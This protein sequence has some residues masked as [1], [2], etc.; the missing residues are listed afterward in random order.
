MGI[1]NK[2]YDK[3][4]KEDFM[5]NYK[6]DLSK[7][8]KTEEE[9][10]TAI[11]FID[12]EMK[13][14]EEL[15]ENPK[16]NLLSILDLRSS[17]S[18]TMDKLY[19][20]SHMK[21]DE[22]AN[23]S[24]NQK[25]AMEM[26]SLMNSIG[27]QFSFIEPLILGIEDKELN[28]IIDS[29]EYSIYKT[30]IKRVIRKK[31]HTLSEKEEFIL[32]TAS[33]MGDCAQNTFY[34]LSYGDMKFP[35]LEKT[36]EKIE[37]THA[38]YTNMLT[39]PN[40]N[41]RQEAF[42]KMYSTYDKYKN[43]F[44]S[45][46]MGAIKNLVIQSK[47]KNF[48]SARTLPLFEDD[49]DLSVYDSLISAVHDKLTTM[50]EY[51]EVKKKGLKLE[52][53]HMY[54]VYVPL[55]EGVDRKIPYEEAKSLI[56]EA[57]KPLGEDYV[58]I[59]KKAFD[60]SWID[61]YPREGK[62]SGAYS[63][64]CYDSNPYILMNYTDDLNSLFTLAHELGHSVH[65]YLS[66]KNNPYI[67]SRYTIFVAEVASTLNELLLMDYMLKTSKDEKEK[68]YLLN[69]HLEQFRTTVF[70]QTMFAEFEREIHKRVENKEALTAKE[71]SDIYYELNK[72]YFG[73]NMKI[74]EQ[75][76]LEWA[77]I[78]HFYSNFY[79]YKYAT[80]FSAATV[81]STKILKSEKG[82]LE[83]YMEFLS[84]G[85]NNFPIDQLKKAGADMSDENTVKSALDVFA[86]EVE[87]IKKLIN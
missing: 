15:K 2:D 7:I 25:L 52:E 59:I 65:S 22:D 69:Y 44:A 12:E 80:G 23:V 9:I 24:S 74:D 53:L 79:V 85:G 45:T 62:K 72:K 76:A 71:F 21:R 16:S 30:Y 84:D 10:N 51:L 35:V 36:E 86:K 20:Y 28:K 66:R 14:L 83:D 64:G 41:I 34:M 27:S 70:R 8:F 75:I 37:L 17:V 26:E 67:N 87:D 61:V 82:T 50:Y 33:E 38:N 60:E 39:N 32:S 77:R 78:P 6:W 49:V 43:T 54:D 4:T 73:E 47:L 55:I 56:I 3:Q 5:E 1:N 58:K 57:L 29:Q 42:E 18:R 40:R 81:L 68:L 13:R 48:E 19:V 63:W 11:K 31:P 46:L